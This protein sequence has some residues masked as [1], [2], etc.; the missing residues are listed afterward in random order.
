MEEDT[1][2]WGTRERLSEEMAPKPRPEGWACAS[3]QRTLPGSLQVVIKRALYRPRAR[4]KR[5]Y[6]QSTYKNP[7]WLELG[8]RKLYGLK[9]RQRGGKGL[10]WTVP[11]GHF[12]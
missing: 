3:V 12:T 9:K 5:W 8:V 10:D 6:F 2:G 7:A 4:E 11:L 1:S